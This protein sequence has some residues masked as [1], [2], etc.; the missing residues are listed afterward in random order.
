MCPDIDL[1]QLTPSE[2]YKLLTALVIPRPIAWVT[3]VDVEGRTNAA[4]Y[5]FF[6]V[7][8]QDPAIVILGLEHKADG[9][10]KDTENNINTQNEFV[11]N[12][13][14]S[15]MLESMVETAA[16]YAPDE[17][18][19]DILGLSLTAFHKVKPPRLTHA[20]VAIECERMMA[21]SLSSE[22]SIMIGRAVSVFSKNGL[23]DATTLNVDWA[24]DYPVARLFADRYA[25]IG[26]ISRYSI[27]VPRRNVQKEE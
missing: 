10:A 22:R 5:S 4:P 12:L 21:L 7:F 8:G 6:N 27:P 1:D 13:V 20:P 3:T 14:T 2:R 23:V 9:T 26:K 15:D 18:E 19:P 11:V 16:S 24:D 25:E 17:S